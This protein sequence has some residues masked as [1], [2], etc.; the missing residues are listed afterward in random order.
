MSSG[1][2]DNPLESAMMR[3]SL[4][5]SKRLGLYDGP[6]R[7]NVSLL[8]TVARGRRSSLCRDAPCC[9]AECCP[10]QS[11]AR[12]ERGS[13]AR[14]DR[15]VQ[16]GARVFALQLLRALL[17]PPLVRRRTRTVGTAISGARR[18]RQQL[19]KTREILRAVT[20]NGNSDKGAPL[21]VDA[22]LLGH[23]SSWTLSSTGLRAHRSFN[24]EE[25]R[26]RIA[27]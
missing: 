9:S 22:H 13:R 11:S 27:A 12:V 10:F 19:R 5:P 6:A 4:L 14:V 18:R 23:T 26:A 21:A 2:K 16:A 20:R 1:S 8:L 7:R 24:D 15:V 3:Q 17:R 25:M